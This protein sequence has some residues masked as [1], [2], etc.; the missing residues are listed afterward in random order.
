MSGDDVREAIREMAAEGEEDELLEMSIM[1]TRP[2]LYDK[3]VEAFGGWDAALVSVL[4]DLA[5]RGRSRSTSSTEETVEREPDERA[6]HPIFVTTDAGKLYTQPGSSLSITESP[7]R[8]ETPEAVG[9]PRSFF[10]LGEPGGVI[11]F[12]DR[13]RYFGLDGRMVPTFS[14]EKPYRD[15]A[16]VL[17]LETGERVRQLLTR[18]DLRGGRIIHITRGAKGKATDADDFGY[19]LDKEGREAFLLNEGDEPVA[20]LASDQDAHV[21]CASANGLGILFESTDLRSMGR[22][23]VGVNVMKLADDDDAVVG[24]FIGEG[25]EN[26]A[27]VTSEGLGKRVKFDE[28][29]PQGRAGAGM[30]L[31]RLNTGDQIASAAACGPSQDLVIVTTAGRVHRLPAHHVPLMG[32]PAKGDRVI[33]LEDGERVSSISALPCSST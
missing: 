16:R 12:T 27:C 18:N 3:A 15:I 20:V 21:F 9:H 5:G 11:V 28:F 4:V 10:H 7:H 30:Q 14:D 33:E 8:L 25:V 6:K 13:G 17:D 23:A 29:R 26:V 24:A 32:R 2:D 31:A 19:V 1:S 22:R